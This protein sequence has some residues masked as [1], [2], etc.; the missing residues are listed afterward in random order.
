MRMGFH[1]VGVVCKLVQNYE[2]DSYIQKQKQY[3]KQY[4]TQKTYETKKGYLKSRI[5]VIR[6]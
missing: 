6:K 5:P 4:K 3:T 2:R 1:P